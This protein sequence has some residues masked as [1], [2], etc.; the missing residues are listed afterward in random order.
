MDNSLA[1]EKDPFTVN[2]FLQAHIN[3]LRYDR[4][5]KAVAAAFVKTKVTPS[6]SFFVISFL[7]SYCLV[8]SRL[9]LVSSRLS[10]VLLC[11]SRLISSPFHPS[12]P[13]LMPSTF[14]R[15][16]SFVSPSLPLTIRRRTRAGAR[17]RR[18]CRRG[19]STGTAPR[20]ASTARPTPRT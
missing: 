13:L 9:S 16:S 20:T 2:D 15:L 11:L 18:R 6:P 12:S 8:L 17:R 7:F 3:K 5:S 19:S 1:R 10:L 4:F 14:S